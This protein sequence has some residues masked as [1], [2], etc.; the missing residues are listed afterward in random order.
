MSAEIFNGV[1]VGGKYR[2]RKYR[3]EPRGPKYWYMP[4]QRN[5]TDKATMLRIA[6]FINLGLSFYHK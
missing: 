6:N 3:R 2:H 5:I 4:K 1:K